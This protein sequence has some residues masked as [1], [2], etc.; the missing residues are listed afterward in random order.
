VTEPISQPPDE[1]LDEKPGPPAA[2]RSEVVALAAIAALAIGLRFWAIGFGLPEHTR[3]D[4]QY[5]VNAVRRFDRLGTLDPA[6]YYYPSF[7]MYVNLGAWR[8]YT[9]WRFFRGDYEPAGPRRQ[10]AWGLERLRARF[11][12][13]EFLLGRCVTAAFGVATVLLVFFLVRRYYGAQAA[14][15]AA[16]LLAV[17]SLHVLNS[18]FYKSD[19]A[20][21]FF[22]IAA[23]ASMARFVEE[24]RK[25]WNIGA[26][27]LTG[28]A[29]STNYY[30]GFV[31]VPLVASQF[32]AN[33]ARPAE[34]SS[35]AAN[36]AKRASL[37]AK[38]S[39]AAA[40]G[41][42]A[43]LRT[44]GR[45]DSYAAPAVAAMAFVAASP[46][47][48]IR[49]ADFLNAFHRM[50]FTDRQSLY[51]TMVRVLDFNDYGFQSSPLAYSLRFC[52]RY[53]MGLAMAIAAAAG[54]VFL[55]LRGRSV[56]RLLVLFAAVHFLM[57]ASGKAVFMRYYL[58][59]APIFAIG[60]GALIASTADRLGGEKALRRNII[61]AAAL[62]V[63]GT[64]GLWTSV[65]QDRL[66]AREDTRAEARRWLEANLP[67]SASVGTP[68]DWWGNFYP[69]GKPTLPQGSR[70]V[71][72]SP[73]DVRRK[74]LRYVLIDSSPLRLYSPPE[75]PQWSSWL[76]RNARLVFEATPYDR[77]A[78]EIRPVYDQLDAFYLPVARFGGIARPGPRIRIYEVFAQQR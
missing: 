9:L 65:A 5:F 51:D 64:E 13:A 47:C 68:V 18:H 22:T 37:G 60:A 39:A 12:D 56:G 32:A 67:R 2:R 69:Y 62:V 50:Y 75:R 14:V 57:T 26:G 59:L 30:G 45:W 58:S 44:L 8:T 21:T 53:S 3:P 36:G 49:W 74:G 55:A 52:W 17:N 66:L 71:A 4:E 33:Y 48:F 63:C 24:G 34:T 70:Y 42:K 54:L 31:V 15:A 43:V 46:Y 20:T 16:L 7:Y 27:I 1:Q 6:W 38:I 19:V 76:K 77:P 29:A 41:G 10:A 78:D 35:R 23:L 40:A 73:A 11:P 61:L 25:S 28:L 72:V